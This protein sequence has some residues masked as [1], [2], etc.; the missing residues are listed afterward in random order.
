M[1]T[2]TLAAI[3]SA[4]PMGQQ[5]YEAEIRRA[6]ASRAGGGE[7]WRFVDVRVAPMRATIPG[8]RRSPRGVLERAPLPLATAVG[9][10]A[11]RTRGLVHRLDLRLPPA[12][13]A[14]V[15]TVHDLP[16]LRFPDE[17]RLPASA[18]AGARRAKVVI[19]PSRFAA[20]EAR[21]LLGVKRIEVIPYG[22]SAAFQAPTAATDELLQRLGIRPP[23][24]LHAAGATARKNLGELARAW[25]RLSSERLDL[26]LVLCGPPDGRRTQAFD[27]LERVVMP[28]RLEPQVV[29][30]LMRRAHAVVVPSVYEGFGLPALEAMACGAPV[31]AARAGALPEVCGDAALLVEP[32]A[33]GLSEGIRVLVLDEGRASDLRERGPARA[34]EFSWEEAA[35]RH[36]EVYSGVIGS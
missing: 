22:L 30:S 28:G 34:S 21:E 23:F 11:Y 19:A 29:A 24:V 1:P 31:V 16:P 3:A 18:A 33:E 5:V 4:N 32:T 8:A 9:A 35:R 26:Q 10:V 2:V 12:P 17:G 6:L 27:G 7:A 15:V 36:V 25:G 14:E 13:G 20:D